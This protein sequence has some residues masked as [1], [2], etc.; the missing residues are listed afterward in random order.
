MNTSRTDRETER[1][2]RFNAGDFAFLRA[3]GQKTE[4]TFPVNAAPRV[5]ENESCLMR[6]LGVP[7]YAPVRA[8]S[9]GCCTNGCICTNHMD[10][11]RGRAPRRCLL[12]TDS[13]APALPR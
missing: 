12:H 4:K 1:D 3:N 7:N 13:T 6:V 2:I 8:I 11:P 5:E 10:I 9:C